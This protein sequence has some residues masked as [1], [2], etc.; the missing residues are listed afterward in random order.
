MCVH[1]FIFTYCYYFRNIKSSYFEFLNYKTKMVFFY[2]NS[3]VKQIKRRFQVIIFTIFLFC[4]G[5]K[6]QLTR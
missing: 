5:K 6:L 4:F 3:K 2:F 1:F